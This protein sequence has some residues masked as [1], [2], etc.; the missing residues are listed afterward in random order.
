MEVLG[1]AGDV[2]GAVEQG[3]GEAL[4]DDGA[5][6]WFHHD[7][8]GHQPRDRGAVL[9]E[10]I[11]IPR[12]R[13]RVGRRRGAVDGVTTGAGAHHHHGHAGFSAAAVDGL[14]ILVV[15]RVLL[16]HGDEAADDLWH[17]GDRAVRR[18]VG[19]DALVESRRSH[20]RGRR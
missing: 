8:L 2:F 12:I 9:E 7:G 17:G 5:A 10:R 16:E 18:L 6:A 1:G 4:G 19:G 3:V 13:M 15:K 14:E 11:T 20:R